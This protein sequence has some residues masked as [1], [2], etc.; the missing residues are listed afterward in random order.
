[1]L[2][3][4]DEARICDCNGVSKGMLV[5]AVREGH[6]SLEALC[7]ATRACTGCG[8]CRPRLRELL[9]GCG[10]AGLGKERDAA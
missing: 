6:G 9:R 7:V 2:D 3:L 5:A 1:V 10:T 8:S 4:P